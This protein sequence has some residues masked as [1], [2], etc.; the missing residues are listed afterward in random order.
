V[1]FVDDVHE[2]AQFIVTL[3]CADR[4]PRLEG[5]DYRDGDIP[6]LEGKSLDEIRQVRDDLDAHVRELLQE[7]GP[8]PEA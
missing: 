4:M 8:G 2:A 7:V 5:K 6:S 1:P 3:A